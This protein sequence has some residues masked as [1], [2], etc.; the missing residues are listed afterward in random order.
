MERALSALERRS[1][2]PQ[3]GL[4][5]ST[6]LQLDPR[7]S[8][9]AYGSGS[10]SEFV[11]KLRDAG[12]LKVSGTGGQATI[13]SKTSAETPAKA[14]VKPDEALA[15]LRDVLET[16]RLEV[17][18]GCVAED[19]E[20][21]MVEEKPMFD[22]Q[23]YGFTEFPELLN[24]AQDKSVVRVEPDE[25]EGLLVYLGPE[26]YPPA[27]PE[28]QDPVREKEPEAMRNVRRRR[29]RKAGI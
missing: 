18:E 13:E 1:V 7:F 23:K 11:D 15:P 27:V 14:P 10:F 20:A 6:M 22:L 2:Q 25:E 4:L 17:E 26:F 5:K 3:L 9:K 29:R 21:W 19:L 8:E 28:S 12:Y 24:F 16:H